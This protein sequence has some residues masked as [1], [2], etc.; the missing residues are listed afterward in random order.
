LIKHV[1]TCALVA[2]L[3]RALLSTRHP[4]WRLPA[5]ADPVAR[6]L[7]PFPRI[8]ATLLLISGAIEQINRAVDTSLQLTLFTRGLVALIVALTIG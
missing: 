1:L 5:I 6:A 2:A 4:S 7:S 3:G 8:V